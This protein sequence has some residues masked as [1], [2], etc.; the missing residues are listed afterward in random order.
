[1]GFS[2]ETKFEA[3]IRAGGRCEC[4]RNNC[5]GHQSRCTKRCTLS[6]NDTFYANL[7][8]D[9]S[10]YRYPGF[11]FHHITSV[12]SGGNDSLS[13][14]EFLCEECHKNTSSYGRP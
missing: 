3:Y 11:E 6:D 14:C 4:T 9:Y 7:A 10:S 12:H 1:M 2:P 8:G 5:T 13:N